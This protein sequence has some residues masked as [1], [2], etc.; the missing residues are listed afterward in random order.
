M[1]ALLTFIFLI[2]FSIISAQEVEYYP[3]TGVYV[4]KYDTVYLK[5]YGDLVIPCYGFADAD[6]CATKEDAEKLVRMYCEQR[7][8]E[9]VIKFKIY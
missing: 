1:K 9:G 5:T 6:H 7:F 4:A 3:E 8:K 2:V